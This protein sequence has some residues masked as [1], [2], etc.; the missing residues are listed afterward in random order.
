LPNSLGTLSKGERREGGSLS[1][2]ALGAVIFWGVSFIA[3]KVAL[4]EISPFTL[5]SLRFGV[6][7]LLLLVHFPKNRVFF[8][9]FSLKDWVYIILLA[10]L[11]IAGHTLLQAYGLL[12]TTAIDTSWIVAVYPIFITIAGRLFLGETLSARKIE[13]VLFGFLG[14]CLVIS[15]GEFAFS[16]F[17]SATTFGDLLI[18]ASAFTWTAFTVGG[19]GFLSKFSPLATISP[20]MTVGF[21]MVLPFGAGSEQWKS[22]LHVSGAAWAGVLFLGVFCSGWA[23]LLWYSAL[24]KL[25]SSRV[26][27]YLYLEPFVT[28]LGACLFLD[29]KIEWITLLGGGLTLWGVYLTR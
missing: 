18:L 24:E 28:L 13:G 12:Y 2:P 29:E 8:R 25:E 16:A 26:G 22:L 23:Y 4:R 27:A 10:G 21:L 14:V 20:I 1:W 19:R 9:G 5:L 7:A 11:G 17:Q 15:K 6:G 3:T